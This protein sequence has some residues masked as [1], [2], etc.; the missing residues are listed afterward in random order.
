M[1]KFF[2]IY[3]TVKSSSQSLP[4]AAAI[5][6]LRYPHPLPA[7]QWKVRSH[8]SCPRFPRH[9]PCKCGRHTRWQGNAGPGRTT[10]LLRS[11]APHRRPGPD[12]PA[13]SGPWNRCPPTS[14]RTAGAAGRRS[15]AAEFGGEA[16]PADPATPWETSGGAGGPSVPCRPRTWAPWGPAGTSGPTHPAAPQC[17]PSP[18]CDPTAPLGPAHLAR[19][20]GSHPLPGILLIPQHPW[21]STATLG[22]HSAPQHP[23]AALTS[24]CLHTAVATT[25]KHPVDARAPCTLSYLWNR[26][27]SLLCTVTWV[28]S[29]HRAKIPALVTL[30]CS[31]WKKKVL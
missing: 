20:L 15:A 25:R 28:L 5:N 11:A 14:S 31:G 26:S 6:F 24:M 12:T 8:P 1:W 18:P 30:Q 3:A 2:P 13:G 16:E 27:C 22:S 7:P 4:E 23:P 17:A 21:V 10:P 29:H 19:C 9:F